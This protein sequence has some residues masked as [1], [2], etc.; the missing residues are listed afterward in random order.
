MKKLL[1]AV[2]VASLVMGGYECTSA[3]TLL[4]FTPVPCEKRDKGKRQ[5][6]FNGLAQGAPTF[7]RA[8]FVAP[9]ENGNTCERLSAHMER[10]VHIYSR[11]GGAE[12]Q[13][14]LSALNLEYR[15][16]IEGALPTELRL[17]LENYRRLCECIHRQGGSGL[18][19]SDIYGRRLCGK[20]STKEKRSEILGKCRHCLRF[21][22]QQ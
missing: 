20:I 12:K 14:R 8:S 19:L 17:E 22:S 16:F 21:S 2:V 7:V 3:F 6:H 9:K 1:L 10:L 13:K 15:A 11:L 5:A 18:S 4:E